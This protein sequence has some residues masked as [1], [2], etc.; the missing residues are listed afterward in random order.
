[1]ARFFYGKQYH[2]A[3]PGLKNIVT[4][5]WELIQNQSHHKEIITEAPP[6]ISQS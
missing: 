4:R 3:F 2:P 5:R 1:M 6:I